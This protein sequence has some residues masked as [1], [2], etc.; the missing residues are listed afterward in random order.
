MT[1]I[2][3][4]IETL[5]KFQVLPPALEMGTY[6]ILLVSHTCFRRTSSGNH[7]QTFHMTV[8]IKYYIFRISLKRYHFIFDAFYITV[9]LISSISAVL[10]NSHPRVPLRPLGFA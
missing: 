5:S 3:V 10:S 2:K 7:F 6:S 1:C 8:K 9:V 4:S